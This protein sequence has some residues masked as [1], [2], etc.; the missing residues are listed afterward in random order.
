MATIEASGHLQGE[1][2]TEAK[3]GLRVSVSAHCLGMARGGLGG[4]PPEKDE[5][6]PTPEPK[7]PRGK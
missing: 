4:L 7:S 2:T 3:A 6:N 5:Q 1:A